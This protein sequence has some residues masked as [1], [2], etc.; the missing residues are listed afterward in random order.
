MFHGN[1]GGVEPPN[2]SA[3]GFYHNCVNKFRLASLADSFASDILPSWRT[4]T[5]CHKFHWVNR[6]TRIFGM[7][8]T[9]G[10]GSTDWVHP[11]NSHFQGVYVSAAP[12]SK[13]GFN[14]QFRKG[15]HLPEKS[16]TSKV[17]KSIGE[18]SEPKIFWLVIPKLHRIMCFH[19][20]FGPHH[21]WIWIRF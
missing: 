7:F 18:R 10:A 12:S 11:K 6:P 13:G 16:S 19:W 9:A 8:W 20:K 2:I 1:F 14:T 4:K 21:L 17:V 15:W 5:K 3:T